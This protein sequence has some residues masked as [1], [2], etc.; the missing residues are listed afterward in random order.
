VSLTANGTSLS[1]WADLGGSGLNGTL[2]VVA[3]S[4]GLDSVFA[5]AGDG[6]IVTSPG[7]ADVPSV[8]TFD[9]TAA[10][11][12]KVLSRRPGSTSWPSPPRSLS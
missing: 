2:S 4:N 11:A 6:T 3:G 5:R 10:A 7:T 8:I 12:A 9:Q 1:D